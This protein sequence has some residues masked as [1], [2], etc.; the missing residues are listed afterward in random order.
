MLFMP[1]ALALC[2]R[3][4]RQSGVPPNLCEYS[5][6]RIIRDFSLVKYKCSPSPT[7][8]LGIGV[9]NQK[10]RSNRSVEKLRHPLGVNS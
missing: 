10:S 1:L 7:D 6:S 2:L 3:V 4:V 9:G 8:G 5:I